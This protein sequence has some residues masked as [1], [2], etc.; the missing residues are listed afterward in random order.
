MY[1]AADANSSRYPSRAFIS[2]SLALNDHLLGF[3]TRTC[4]VRPAIAAA[5]GEKLTTELVIAPSRELWWG[6]ARLSTKPLR[7]ASEPGEGLTFSLPV[8]DQDGYR[9]HPAGDIIKPSQDGIPTHTYT[10]DITTYD[11]RGRAVDQRRLWF[12]LPAGDSPVTIDALPPATEAF[13]SVFGP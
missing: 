9:A 4:N 5:S 1:L 10:A 12:V 8:T 13:E 3:I 2:G 7:L 11:G 6:H